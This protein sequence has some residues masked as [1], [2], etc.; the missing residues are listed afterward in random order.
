MFCYRMACCFS[1]IVMARR[2][3]V[4]G[5]HPDGVGAAAEERHVRKGGD[6]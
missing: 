2:P 3:Y 6:A 4:A 1:T 5:H